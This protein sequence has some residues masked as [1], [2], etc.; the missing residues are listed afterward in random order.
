MKYAFISDIH[1]NLEALTATLERIDALHVDR[2]LCLGDLVGYFANPNECVEIICS[3]GIPCIMGNHDRAATGAKEPDQFGEAG[4][5]AIYWTRE[6]LTAA[7]RA[8][9]DS[10]PLTLEIDDRLLMVH[11]SLYPEPNE[12]LHMRADVNVLRSFR[13]LV[14]EWPQLKICL[15]GHTH[16]GAAYEFLDGEMQR[17]RADAVVLNPA[18]RYQVNPGSVGQPRDGD[19]R[20][21]FALFDSAAMKLQFH[22]VEFDVESCLAKASREGLLYREGF[23]RQSVNWVADRIESKTSGIKRRLGRRWQRKRPVFG[24]RHADRKSSD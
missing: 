22:R 10:L 5:R 13:R 6:R 17:I 18:A 16:H 4:R 12:D 3:R 24:R 21:A 14:T 15:F 11:G 19:P 7:T 8:Y 1:A 20:A 2:I 23:V 9:L